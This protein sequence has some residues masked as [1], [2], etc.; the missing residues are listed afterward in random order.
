M[1]KVQQTTRAHDIHATTKID[2][3]FDSQSEHANTTMPHHKSKIVKP[4]LAHIDKNHDTVTLT[5]VQKN[6]RSLTSEDR[7][8]ELVQELVEFNDQ[9][10]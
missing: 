3:Q 8:H 4:Q 6:T 5:L 9:K 10:P 7:I 1:K 2:D